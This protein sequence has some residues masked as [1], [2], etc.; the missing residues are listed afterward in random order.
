RVRSV[1]FDLVCLGATVVAGWMLWRNGLSGPSDF[2]GFLGIPYAFPIYHLVIGV[3][4]AVTP[5]SVVIGRLLDNAAVKYVAQIS[6]GLYVWHYVVLELV[7][8]FWLPDIDHGSMRDGTRF[9]IG[10]AVILGVTGVIAD[11]SYRWLE[12]PVIDWARRLERR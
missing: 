3:I 5:S 11:R 1:A 6:F 10:A 4:L 9:F 12:A 2:H 7:R 8:V